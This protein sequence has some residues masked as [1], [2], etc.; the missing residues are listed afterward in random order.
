MKERKD[1][2]DILKGIGIILMV[3]GHMHFNDAVFNKYI[4]GFHMPLFFLVSGYLYHRPES[5]GKAVVKKA[6]TMLIPY[7]TFGMAYYFLWIIAVYDGE[8]H[9]LSPLFSILFKVTEGL[10]IESALWFLPV[11]MLTY[12]LYYALERNISAIS[13]R[14]TAVLIITFSGCLVTEILYEHIFGGIGTAMSAIGF[15]FI[16]HMAAENKDKS[17]IINRIIGKWYVFVLLLILN[18]VMIF[19]NEKVNMRTGEWAVVPVSY[20][21][22][23]LATLLYCKISVWIA[24]K[25]IISRAVK[26][27]GKNS[28]VFLCTNHLAIIVSSKL[29]GFMHM[30]HG[31]VLYWIA[32][33]IISMLEMIIATEL[34]NRTQLRIII[35]KEFMSNR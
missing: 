23:L 3:L 14:A 24:G 9:I 12:F 30:E 5:F 15:F 20:I 7:Y 28:I 31:T 11:L 1:N 17:V 13:L 29:L 32:V 10:P 27:I 2:I 18:T 21:N 22:A 8:T 25:E 35:G 26:Y 16:G 19:M 34:I 33:F 6:K 4:F